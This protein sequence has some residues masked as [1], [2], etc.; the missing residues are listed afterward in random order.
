MQWYVWVPLV[1]RSMPYRRLNHVR[2]DIGRNKDVV[3]DLLNAAKWR[4]GT[5]V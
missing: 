4:Q 2:Y 5:I 3:S 1:N